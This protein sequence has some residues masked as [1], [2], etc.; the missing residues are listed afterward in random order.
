MGSLEPGSCV[1]RK[2]TSICDDF[3]VRSPLNLIGFWLI[4]AGIYERSRGLEK[5]E[6]QAGMW[7]EERRRE[8]HSE[9]SVF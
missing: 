4:K 8:D 5:Y 7:Q 3:A 1:R 2:K 9:A 6:E